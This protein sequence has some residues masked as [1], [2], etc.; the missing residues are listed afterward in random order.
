MNK[1]KKEE[2]KKEEKVEELPEI[3][4]IEELKKALADETARADANMAG[5]QRAQADFQNYKRFV[6]QDK[7][8]TVKYANANLLN[9]I[10]PVLDDLERA[11]KAI[12]EEFTTYDWVEGVRLVEKKLGIRVGI[13]SYGPRPEETIGTTL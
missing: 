12:P 6:E 10:L 8:E 5:W 11:I 13:V 7:V 2:I 3:K 9:G 1:E 4:D